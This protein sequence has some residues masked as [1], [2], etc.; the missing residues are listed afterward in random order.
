MLDYKIFKE[1][2]VEKIRDYLPEE[3]RSL[4][5]VVEKVDKVNGAKDGLRIFD[6]EKS[7]RVTPTIYLNDVYAD[8]KKS[9]DLEAVLQ[10]AADNITNGFAYAGEIRS[11]LNF[12]EA[13]DNIVFQL[14]NT[15][16]NRQMLSQMPHREFQDLSI[17]YRWVVKMDEGGLQSTMIN[18][19]LAKQMGLDEEELFRLASKNT[20]RILPP[21]VKTM[22]E[23]MREIF[24]KDD[25][26]QEII[27]MMVE[28]M[29]KE[30]TMWIITND[31]GINGAV[32]MLYEDRLQELAKDMG[33]DLFVLPSSVHEVIAISAK[34]GDPEE[35]ARM[36]N[37]IN[38]SQVAPEERLSNQVY[39]YDKDLRRLTLAT[40]TPNKRL[41]GNVVEMEQEAAK[42]SMT[43]E[44]PMIYA[45]ENRSR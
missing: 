45:N 40:D 43:A 30:Q 14:I 23:V 27:D 15:E 41:D 28:E 31:R 9:E 32:S 37:E 29:P 10:K 2:V 4:K 7:M 16:Q 24:A 34:M 1:A 42:K 17:I 44:P 26:P 19:N 8:Y 35:L 5:I 18:E 6:E 13:K 3:Y 33:E 11:E 21:V 38:L 25:M 20:K 36:V 39:H 12:E 22:T